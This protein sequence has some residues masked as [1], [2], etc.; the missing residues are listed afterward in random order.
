MV[1]TPAEYPPLGG[2]CD[3]YS[4]IYF[5]RLIIGCF[6]FI[7]PVTMEEA[8]REKAVALDLLYF[9]SVWI[10]VTFSVGIASLIL[11]LWGCCQALK[12]YALLFIFEEGARI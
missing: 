9:C 6:S 11:R 3:F 7:L 12:R 1:A 5:P 2:D 4:R 8:L 10:G